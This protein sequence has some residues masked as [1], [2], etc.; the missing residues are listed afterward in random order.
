LDANAPAL[1][2]MPL[3]ASAASLEV[4]SV[5]RCSFCGKSPDDVR[6][7]LTRGETAIFDECVFL[8]F[9][10]IGGQKGYFYQRVAYSVFKVVAMVGRFLT[11]S[12]WRRPRSS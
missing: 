1:P 4:D 10:T 2:P 3:W 11:L 5:T 7:I 6:V 9:D 8:A 12:P